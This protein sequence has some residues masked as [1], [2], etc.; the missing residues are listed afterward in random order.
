L[1]SSPIRRARPQDADA[2]HE[3]VQRAYAHYPRVIGVRP[4]PMDADYPD[5]IA[6]K[7]VWVAESV[8]G[9]AGAIVMRRE[10]DHVFIDN[11]AV[12]PAHQGAGIGRALLEQAEGRAREEGIDELQLLTHE[13]MAENRAMYARLGWEETEHRDEEGF[14]RVYFRKRLRG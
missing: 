4:A 9:V 7:E 8:G 5:E 2:I 1:S 3:L 10:A 14:A 12:D 6:T 13:L 11:V